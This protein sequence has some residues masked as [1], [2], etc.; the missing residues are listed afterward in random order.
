MR[1]HRP[2]YKDM[3]E[4]EKAKARARSILRKAVRSGAIEKEPCKECGSKNS[5]A[6][7]TDYAYPL[8]V[9]WLCRRCHMEE[10]GRAT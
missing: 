9:D 8:D 10:H 6:H 1:G 3:P 5:E 2:K 4:K 7:H